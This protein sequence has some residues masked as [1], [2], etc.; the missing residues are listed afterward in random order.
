MPL[1]TSQKI[2]MTPIGF[3]KRSSSKENERDRNL[4]LKIV[5]RKRLASVIKT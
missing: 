3:V 5:L 2:E 1:P 4:V